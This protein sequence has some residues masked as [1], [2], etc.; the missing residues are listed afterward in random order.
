MEV[1][2]L[3][4]VFSPSEQAQRTDQLPG[5]RSHDVR[6]QDLVRL[7]VRDEFHD[8]LGIVRGARAAVGHE[9]ELPR[10]VG[11]SGGFHLLLGLPHGGA[12]GP[13]VDNGG[14]GRVVDVA[15]F[16]FRRVCVF[17]FFGGGG[18]KG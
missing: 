7:G 14:D 1:E 13:G 16:A 10:L 15:G 5:V 4:R 17:F 11:R 12:L 6:S 18:R 9:R 3:F 2:T 8:A